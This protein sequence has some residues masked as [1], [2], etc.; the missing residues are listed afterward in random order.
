MVYAFL[1]IVIYMICEDDYL[2]VSG[3]YWRH[4]R[5]SLQQWEV[6]GWGRDPFSTKLN[7]SQE[8]VVLTILTLYIWF[9]RMTKKIYIQSGMVYAFLYI[10]IYMICEDDYLSVSGQIVRMTIYLWVDSPHKSYIGSEYCQY[11]SHLRQINQGRELKS[12][13]VE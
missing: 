7:L 1:Y 5:R 12:D 11:D 6:R 10:V 3:Q 13:S 4:S 2:S 8:S 9:V